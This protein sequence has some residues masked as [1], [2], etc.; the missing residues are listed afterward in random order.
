MK[1]ELIHYR[2]SLARLLGIVISLALLAWV[3]RAFDLAEV[4]RA[5]QAANYLYLLPVAVLIVLNYTARALRWGT[6][7]GDA[8]VPCWSSL[9]VTMMI[10]YLANN[11]LPARAGELVRAYMLGRREG[12]AKST[13][14]ATVVMER[15]ADLVVA[16]LLLAVVLL[17]YPLPAW[18]GRVGLVVGAVS[19][20]ALAI[21]VLLSIWGSRL[22]ARMVRL[23]HFLPVGFVSR[24]EA[25]GDGFVAGVS[26]LRSWRRV[27]SFLGCTMLIWFLEV[28][29]VWLIAQAFRLPLSVGGSL[30][31]MLVV[32]LGTM[33]PSS[34]GYVGTYEFFATSA[35]ALL[36]V[37]G[38]LALSFA[39]A[40]HA[41]TFLGASLLGAA[42]LALTGRDVTRGTTMPW[43]AEG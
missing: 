24:I 14:L 10:G 34:P 42:C 8:K 27:G 41:V 4:G 21:L 23:L 31:V 6:L 19:L 16:L 29:G 39:L 28:L 13:V 18:L 38:G 22:V 1:S 40:M 37:T 5:L 26:G 3:L 11:I 7:F 25:V 2:G 32:G 12:L 33:V 43:R 35:L 36:G 17:F 30:F 9:F 20:T 15:V